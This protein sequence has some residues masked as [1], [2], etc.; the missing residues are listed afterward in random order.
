MT[1][2]PSLG[3]VGAGRVGQALVLA[4]SQRGYPILGIA[5]R[6]ASTAERLKEK[7]HAQSSGA[8]ASSF[9]KSTDVLFLAV[10][11][12]AIK[13]VCDGIAGKGGFRKGQVVAH[14]SGALS[15][16]ILVS[17]KM[18]GASTLAFHPLQS[19]SGGDQ[20][21]ASL[22]SGIY[23]VLQG[24]GEAV[25]V[26]KDLAHALDGFPVVIGEKGKALYHAGA[27]LLSNG[28]VALVREGTRMFAE[29]GIKPEE[30]VS[31][32]LPLLRGTIF[33]MEQGG[34]LEALTGPIE[35]GDTETVKV[36]LKALADEYPDGLCFY[37]LLGMAIFKAAEEKG[38]VSP[39]AQA[40]LSQILK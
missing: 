16:G 29:A 27:S 23:F 18:Y 30:A 5:S 4:F 19:F 14:T 8:D 33:N 15:A 21:A 7:A 36:H 25:E 31:M 12:Q 1:T 40:E 17:A 38:N 26:G 10:P 22:L 9:S 24:D 3:F 6:D 11:D 37:R 35:R 20:G 32:T 2:K 13:G 28:L 34:V 39:A